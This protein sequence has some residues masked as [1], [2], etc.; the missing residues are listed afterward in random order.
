MIPKLGRQL[1]KTAEAIE[2]EAREIKELA[3][4]E[5]W[6]GKTATEFRSAAEGAGDK[7]R[8]AF[9]RYDEA[10]EALGTRVVDGVCSTEFASELHRAQQMADKALRD[11][12]AADDERG[13]AQRSLDGQPD[14]TPKDD[15]DTK[16]YK[17]QKENAS[18]AL[19]SAKDALQTAKEVRDAAAR[20]AADAI[21]DVIENDGLKDGWK[22]KF[23][24]WVHENAGGS[25]KSRTGR[26]VSPC[27]RAS[28]RWPWAGSP[29]SGRPSPP[30]P[31]RSLW[32]RVSSRSPQ[33][34][35]WHSEARAAGSRCS[36]TPS[37]WQPSVSG[38]R[39][40]RAPREWPPAPRRWP[41]ALSTRTPSRPA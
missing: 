12:E 20:R 9:K 38:G 10:A 23:K 11:A 16:K 39:R 3:S 33:T 26:D 36:W 7:L 41:G 5:N 19:S 2:K 37:E 21:H 24:D 30:S 40:W 29:S 22:D 31:T 27:G 4:V 14:D 32:W 15:P 6:K 8:K 34:W 35:Y 13:A 1:R 17:E 18:S 28:R 25:P